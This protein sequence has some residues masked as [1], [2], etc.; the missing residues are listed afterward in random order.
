MQLDSCHIRN[1]RRLLD[2][3]IDL[4]GKTTT[5]VGANNS[6][7]TTAAQAFVLFLE[8]PPRGKFSIHDFNNGVWQAF[9]QAAM[10]EP[11]AMPFPTI[12]LDLWFGVDDESLH[13]VYELLPDLDWTRSKVGIRISYEARD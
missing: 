11:G 10:A 1:L 7:K 6:G 9:N 4:A 5:F 13:R 3:H 2:V 8:S 12:S